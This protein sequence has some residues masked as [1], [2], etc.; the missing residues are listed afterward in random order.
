MIKFKK[1]LSKKVGQPPGTLTYTGEEPYEKHPVN[2]IKYNKQESTPFDSENLNEIFSQIEPDKVNWININ[3]LHD[4]SIIEQL[5]VKFDLHNLVLEDVLN[6]EHLP[7]IENFD[8]YIFFT[9]KMLVVNSEDKHIEHEHLSF[10]IGKNYI[11]SFQ[12]KKGDIFNLIRERIFEGKGKARIR[13]SDFLFYLLIDK[14]VDNYFVVIENIREKIENLE[15]ELINNPSGNLINEIHAQKKQL[16]FIQKSIFP[17]REALHRLMKEE[18]K[19]IHKT[20]L[21][22]LNDV[23]DHVLHLI[24]VYNSSREMTKSLID[25]NL[26]NMNT[27]MNNVMKT[28]T[29]VASIFIPLTFLAGIYGMNFEYMPELKLQWAYP[30]LLIIMVVIG[31]GMFVYMKRK[32]WF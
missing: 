12:E 3:N 28:L 4:V 29:V 18:S 9:L 30:V 22:Y 7:K 19:L 8:D 27:N 10:I 17:L 6:T 15:D 20:T 13:K 23:Y 16:V 25:L 11:L 5:G 1:I 26:S 24:E 14:I 2:L 32:K 31:L 21:T